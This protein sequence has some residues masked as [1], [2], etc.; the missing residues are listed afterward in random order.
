MAHWSLWVMIFSETKIGKQ[1][2][3]NNYIAS[4]IYK[5]KQEREDYRTE[6]LHLSWGKGLVYSL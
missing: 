4:D 5:D 3:F 2:S 6:K 1:V